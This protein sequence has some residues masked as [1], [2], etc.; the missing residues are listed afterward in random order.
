MSHEKACGG[1]VTSFEMESLTSVLVAIEGARAPVGVATRVIAIDGPGGAGKTTLAA[2]LAEALGAAVIHTDDFASSEN[3]VE[4][5]PELIERALKP[6]A[7]GKPA[8]YRP[9][10][11]AGDERE[12][13][14]IVP[15]GTVLL[16]GVTASRRAFRPYLAYSIWV[17]TDRDVRLQRGLDRDGEG[18]RSQWERWIAAEDQYLE[19]ERPADH[20]ELVLR[21]DADLWK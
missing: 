11:W 20:V 14:E 18:S 3:P 10:P 1:S 6:L 12:L 13:I 17:E 4:W 5:W 16:E 7:A 19:S 2:W 21:G 8:R 15:G 9:T